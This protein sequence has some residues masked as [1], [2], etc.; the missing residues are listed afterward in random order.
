MIFRSMS[1]VLARHPLMVAMTACLLVMFCL[2]ALGRTRRSPKVTV[3]IGAVRRVTTDPGGPRLAEPPFR[4]QVASIPSVQTATGIESAQALALG[5][6][7]TAF[8]EADAG[9]FISSYPELERAATQRGLIP[10]TV[11]SVRSGVFQADERQ[12]LVRFRP[13][14]L[15]VE[16]VVPATETAPPLIVRIPAV[17]KAGYFDD[18]PT[19]RMTG[20]TRPVAWFVGHLRTAIP[21]PFIQVDEL[22]LR[23]WRPEA[24]NQREESIVRP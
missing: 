6:W 18:D 2:V 10:G 17:A 23:G 12:L 1:K 24:G 4:Q 9:N 16:I 5:L 13:K 7:G 3:S 21:E 19:K 11:Q 14:P 8:A 15:A 20:G 22:V